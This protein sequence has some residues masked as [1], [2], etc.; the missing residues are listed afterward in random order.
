MEMGLSQADA[1][2]R[3]SVSRSK[4]QRLWNYFQST[5]SVSRRPVPSRLRGTTS[6][7]D[8]NLTF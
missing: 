1:A 7:E 4:V 2:R 3:L 5:D 8:H 6:S